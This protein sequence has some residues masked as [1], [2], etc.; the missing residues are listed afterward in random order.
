MT[1][2]L[3]HKVFPVLLLIFFIGARVPM[4]LALK[5]QIISSTR[6]FELT[7]EFVRSIETLLENPATNRKLEIYDRLVYGKGQ[8]LSVD[9]KSRKN[10]VLALDPQGKYLIRLF[11][12]ADAVD[13]EKSWKGVKYYT[14]VCSKA[15]VTSGG[16]VE[17]TLT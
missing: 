10:A 9:G 4:V 14:G 6:E 12:I 2:R 1:V 17:I 5:R 3:S 13:H 8:F 11:D 7:E 15:E 16:F